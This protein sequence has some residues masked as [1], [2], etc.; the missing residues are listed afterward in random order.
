MTGIYEWNPMPHIVD[1]RCPACGGHAEF[2][3]AETVRIKLK[4]DVEFFKKSK[5]FEYRFL[6]DSCGSG[7]HAAV[8][9]PRVHGF[10][11]DVLD[12]LPAGYSPADWNHSRYLC[13][14]HLRCSHG[15]VD[16]FECK[17]RQKHVLSWPDEAFYQIVFRRK[18]LWAFH[19]E[20]AV[21]IR[22]FIASADREAAAFRWR[23]LLRH[24]PK[25][26]LAAKA[27]DGIVKRLDRLLVSG[28]R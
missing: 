4:K 21:E 19:R 12:D 22:D 9:Y 15:A 17:L 16:C 24:L 11:T 28:I 2:E 26:F 8:Y 3:F 27:R 14:R 10:S 5:L 13:P 18:V 23:L 1:I 6:R 25:E 20:S 7:W